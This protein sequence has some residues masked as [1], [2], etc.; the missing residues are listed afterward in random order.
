MDI[1]LFDR[2]LAGI[3]VK[4]LDAHL[5]AKS[6]SFIRNIG[7]AGV[8]VCIELVYFGIFLVFVFVRVDKQ[9]MAFLG[10]DTQLIGNDHSVK[11]AVDQLHIRGGIDGLGA[12][13][14]RLESV[15]DGTDRDP[16]L[17]VFGSLQDHGAVLYR[18]IQYQGIQL[19]AIVLVQMPFVR[20][21]F[22]LGIAIAVVEVQPPVCH[23]IGR[24]VALS[25]YIG[26]IPADGKH[27]IGLAGFGLG[28]GAAVRELITT[29]LVKGID[30]AI[31]LRLTVLCKSGIRKKAQQRKKG[32]PG[33]QQSGHFLLGHDDH[34]FILLNSIGH[35]AGKS[36]FIIL[37]YQAILCRTIFPE[38]FIANF[39]L[40]KL[41]FGGQ[42]QRSA[43]GGTFPC[44]RRL[45]LAKH[46]SEKHHCPILRKP[47]CFP[48][49]PKQN[50]AV[51][52][53]GLYCVN[54]G[55]LNDTSA[56]LA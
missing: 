45:K 9:D 51:F 27:T 39:I 2:L 42:N 44:F 32:A 31:H 21:S 52:L 41:R 24:N 33:E 30:P 26:N 53:Y 47:P 48:R 12:N 43:G 40:R 13:G 36:G 22:Q 20:T 18:L 15:G 10:A 46:Y 56:F 49:W 34:D 14:H 11:A 5:R 35:P 38:S 54:R 23:F 16:G 55:W 28:K 3:G 25:V 19:L 1:P 8:A 29:V 17:L 37:L 7:R 6:V 50:W 4:I